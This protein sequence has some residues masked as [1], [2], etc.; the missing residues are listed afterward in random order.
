MGLPACKPHA[1]QG[2]RQSWQGPLACCAGFNRAMHVHVVCSAVYKLHQAA[3]LPYRSVP[4]CC[5][6]CPCLS[7]RN[8]ALDG[9]FDRMN[10]LLWPR[11]KAS[12]AGPLQCYG[13]LRLQLRPLS[14]WLP[15]RC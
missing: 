5:S 3:Q 10:L 4:P 11:L 15:S 2:A 12:V 9:H 1:G 6:C 13:C 8:P 14:A 7:R